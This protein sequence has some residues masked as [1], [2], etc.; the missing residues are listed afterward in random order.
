MIHITCT[1]HMEPHFHIRQL[2]LI[3]WCTLFTTGFVAYL[4]CEYFVN[5]GGSER[6][7]GIVCCAG[8]KRE[9]VM[10]N[11]SLHPHHALKS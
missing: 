3:L 11:S 2:L 8:D 10:N 6:L 1:T 5:W 7:S 9:F 4:D